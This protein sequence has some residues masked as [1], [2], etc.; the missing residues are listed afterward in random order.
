[1]RANQPFVVDG[2]SVV[3][4]MVGRGEAWIGLTDSDDIGAEQRESAPLAALPVNEET[5]FIPNTVALVRAA[6]HPRAGEKLQQ[7]LQKPEVCR[8]LADAHAL[9]GCSEIPV[10]TLRPDWGRLLA[11][12]EPATSKLK[13]I[14]LR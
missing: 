14:F 11:E 1:L 3:A 4:K 6:P 10:R 2:N 9:E 7:F 8:M 13:E 12:L 5:L